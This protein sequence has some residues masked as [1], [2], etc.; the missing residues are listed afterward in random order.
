[1]KFRRFEG[2][3]SWSVFPE[4]FRR[5]GSRSSFSSHVG[6]K[7][8]VFL[9]GE[10]SCFSGGGKTESPNQTITMYYYYYYYYYYY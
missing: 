1:M 6:R 4:R 8:R 5:G 2:G 9:G 3:G 10:I 7:F